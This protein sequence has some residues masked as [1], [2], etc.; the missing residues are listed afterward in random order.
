ML[1]TLFEL[2]GFG[3]FPDFLVIDFSVT[4]WVIKVFIALLQVIS[5]RYQEWLK[6]FTFAWDRTSQFIGQKLFVALKRT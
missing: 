3:S 4:C 6:S 2:L 1:D 5:S